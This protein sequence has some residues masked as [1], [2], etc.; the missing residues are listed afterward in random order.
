M[1]KIKQ[2]FCFHKYGK[3]GESNTVFFLNCHKCKKVL[4]VAKEDI[5][6][7]KLHGTIK[8]PSNNKIILWLKKKFSL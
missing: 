7:Y 4:F 6:N 3:F 2:F 1:L 8:Q 5:S